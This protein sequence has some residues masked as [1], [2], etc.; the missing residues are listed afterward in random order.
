MREAPSLHDACA[1]KFSSQG[2]T[3]NRKHIG[4]SISIDHSCVPL[5]LKKSKTKDLQFSKC[6]VS[7]RKSESCAIACGWE[8]SQIAA[9]HACRSVFVVSGWISL[10]NHA[11]LHLL[12]LGGKV[13][14]QSARMI[15]S[16]W[17]N[18]SVQS[19]AERRNQET[20]HRK[21][22]ACSTLHA[23]KNLAQLKLMLLTW[24]QRLVTNNLCWTTQAIRFPQNAKCR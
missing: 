22:F 6:P 12:F 2:S 21:K 8:Q 16:F 9:A 23:M 18:V 13:S 7:A 5:H 20:R 14:H 24:E 15:F 11:D 19:A 4:L 17:C 1:L 3:L 10:I